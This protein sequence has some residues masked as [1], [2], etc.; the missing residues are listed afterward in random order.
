MKKFMKKAGSLVTAA[1]LTLTIFQVAGFGAASS[2]QPLRGAEEGLLR[3]INVIESS[4]DY[5][6]EVTRGELAYVAARVLAA[7]EDSAAAAAIPNPA[8]SVW[9]ITAF[10]F[11]TNCR[12]FGKRRWR[13]CASRWRT[14]R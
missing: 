1:A 8:R 14:A 2:A 5:N 11:W 7:P 9:R 10:C 6:K 3:H 13:F 12:S 4:V